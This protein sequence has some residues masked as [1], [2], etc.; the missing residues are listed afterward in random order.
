[1]A[2]SLDRF[3]GRVVLITG[4]SAG[5]GLATARRIT[6]EGGTVITVARNQERLTAA[7][8]E[9]PDG[10]YQCLACDAFDESALTNAL[11]ALIGKVGPLYSAI[12]CAG[13]HM[14][15]PLA[16]CSSLHFEDMFRKNVGTAVSTIRVFLKFKE[17][18]S[19]N[20]VLVSSAAA[21]RGGAAVAAYTAAKGA[22]LSLT[23]SLA[24][25]LAPRHV[26]VNAVIPGVVR[27]K[28][29][30]AFLDRLSEEQK[31]AVI[32]GHLLGI[33]EPNDVAAAITFL[34]SEDSRWIT[35]AELVVDGGLT[36]K[37]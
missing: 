2:Y 27:S 13:A 11:Q 6:A 4:A 5:I 16:V 29:S 17:A 9:L 31:Q 7:S 14:V 8:R 33:G 24:V 32:S 34:A 35:G 19:S 15:R 20:V 1:M 10:S 18:Q 12:L 25:E 22:L 3:A 30:D 26:R 36:C 23:R 28:M 37:S 21:T